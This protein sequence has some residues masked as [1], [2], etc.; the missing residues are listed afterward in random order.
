MVAVQTF[1]IT[2]RLRDLTADGYRAFCGELAPA[3]AETPGLLATIWL[4]NSGT[5]IHGSVHLFA[6]TGAA[7][8]FVESRLFRTLVLC[9]HLADLA[10]QRFTVDETTTRRTQPGLGIV[11]AR[12]VTLWPTVRVQPSPGAVTTST[13]R[14][15]SAANASF[16]AAAADA[17]SDTDTAGTP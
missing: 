11:P 12:A 3:L 8:A 6:H 5:G 7:D 9:P 15:P 1:L 17:A 16:S 10:V 2:H 14:G 4:G 13:S